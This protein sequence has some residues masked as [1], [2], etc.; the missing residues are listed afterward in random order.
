MNRALPFALLFGLLFS[1]AAPPSEAIAQDEARLLFER[2]NRHFATGMR[3]RGARRTRA[4]EEALDAYL[5]VLRLGARTRNVVFN[6]AVTLEELDRDPEAFNYFAD[7]LR[8]F[9]LSDA[10]RA[11]GQRRVE[12]LRPRV[13]A[14]SIDSTPQ[15]A[16][17][18]VDRRD[19]P[20]RGQTPMELA[21]PAGEHT[22]FVVS[23]GYEESTTTV[24]AT[25]GSTAQVSLELV[26]APVPV[27]VIAPG[28]GR[29]TMDGE[30]M[31]AG[32]S[33]PVS[34]GPHVVRL[35]VP[36]APPIERHFEVPA[37]G[38]PMVLELAGSSAAV[39]SRVALDVESPSIVF[40]DGVAVGRGTHVEFPAAPG[41]HLLRVESRGRV[42]ATHA[43]SLNPGQSLSLDAELGAR[44]GGGVNAARVI[45]TI[46]GGVGLVGS[47]TL[48]GLTVDAR[49][50]WDTA[51]TALAEMRTT[52][53]QANAEAVH[54]ELSTLALATDITIGVTA[55]FG[56]LAIVFFIIEPEADGESTVTVAA[57]PEVGGAS[58]ALNVRWDR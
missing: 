10:D 28:G 7:Y 34:P 26:G 57:R 25:V 11:E 23:H 33:V 48:L 37:G 46:L 29:L 55:L 40:L 36:G 49:S 43:F 31:A 16:A 27:Q 45:F 41:E 52:Q 30:E 19:L 21:L 39:P 6:L 2:A 20:V 9:E 4:L 17:V 38:Q 15:G 22:L 54:A 53:T 47:A 58:L 42:A 24:T 5:G 1:F 18:R 12:A 56:A 13:A 35:E 44:G 3:A 50:R 14:V 8:S 51:A 32:R